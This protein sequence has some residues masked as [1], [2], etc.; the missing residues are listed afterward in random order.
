[1]LNYLYLFFRIWASFWHT[2]VYSV[3]SFLQVNLSQVLTRRKL[4]ESWVLNDLLV[5]RNFKWGIHSS[6]F[7][8]LCSFSNTFTNF[9][10]LGKFK[11]LLLINWDLFYEILRYSYWVLFSTILSFA[12]FAF[13][14]FYHSLSSRLWLCCTLWTRNNL[15][16][17]IINIFNCLSKCCKFL[18]SVRIFASHTYVIDF[19]W[20]KNAWNF[21]MLSQIICWR[22]TWLITSDVSWNNNCSISAIRW[23]I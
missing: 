13:N 7:L 18:L 10:N 3:C 23:S 5:S 11:A 8:D 14:S 22:V 19:T 20:V 9:W 17:R 6:A 16:S 21:S 15:L 4:A 1:M 12:A 2:Q